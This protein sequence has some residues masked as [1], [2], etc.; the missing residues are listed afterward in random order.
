MDAL[1]AALAPYL[2]RCGIGLTGGIGTGKST[3]AGLL[4]GLGV[5]VADADALARGVTAP[6]TPG[7]AQVAAAFGRELIGPDGALDRRRLR[8]IIFQDPAKRR[9]LERI[10]HPLVHQAMLDWLTKTGLTATPRYFVYEASLLF[11]TGRAAEFRAV[12]VTTCPREMQLARVM[13]RDGVDRAAAEAALAAQ[14]DPAL[15]AAQ[16]SAVIPTDR[17]LATVRTQVEALLAALGPLC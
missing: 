9:E 5:P 17:P 12:W 4:T 6:G 16:A 1:K 3:V 8:A 14:M 7:L 15:K 11:E 2:S 10:T 13:A